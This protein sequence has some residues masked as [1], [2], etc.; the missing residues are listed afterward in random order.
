MTTTSGNCFLYSKYIF[1]VPFCQC[2]WAGCHILPSVFLYRYCMSKEIFYPDFHIVFYCSVQ[3]DQESDCG[4]ME[5]FHRY[6]GNILK[7]Y[8]NEYSFSTIWSLCSYK[9]IYKKPEC[10]I[11]SEIGDI[12]EKDIILWLG[13]T[14]GIFRRLAAE[15]RQKSVCLWHHREHGDSNKGWRQRRFEP[16]QETDVKKMINGNVS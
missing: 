6:W 10:K 7:C 11:R 1:S 15:W 8:W 5:F 3:I 13:E 4:G 14:F 16:S 2:D 12:N 9:T